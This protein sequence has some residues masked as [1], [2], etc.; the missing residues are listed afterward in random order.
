MTN[1]VLMENPKCL[2]GGSRC[3]C[4]SD[5]RNAGSGE[6]MFGVHVTLVA[7]SMWKDSTVE[8]GY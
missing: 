1:F 2:E 6:R 4:S 7:Q 5:G 3:A 8:A